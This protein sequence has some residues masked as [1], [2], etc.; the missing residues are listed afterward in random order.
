MTFKKWPLSCRSLNADPWRL[1]HALIGPWN[2]EHFLF[3][4]FKLVSQLILNPFIPVFATTKRY[5]HKIHALAILDVAYGK[6]K[7]E[8]RK[9]SCTQFYTEGNHQQQHKLAKRFNKWFSQKWK[10][11]KLIIYKSLS[12]T[13]PPMCLGLVTDRRLFLWQM[14]RVRGADQRMSAKHRDKQKSNRLLWRTDEL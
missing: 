10:W 13:R 11:E 9:S 5:Q 3:Q 14:S 6:S 8:H 1:L 4:F 2:K 12:C 7:Q